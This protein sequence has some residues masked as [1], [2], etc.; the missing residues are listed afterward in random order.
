MRR[1]RGAGRGGGEA[2]FTLVEVLVAFAIASLASLMV[3]RLTGDLTVNGRRIDAAAIRLDEAEGLILVRVAAGTLR[4][5]FEQGRFGDG[6]P[7]TL[8]VVDAG[9]VLGWRDLPPLWRVRLTL[10]GP[11]GRVVYATLV[12]GGLGGG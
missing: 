10:G 1:R 12:A 5:G 9:P 3:L 7:W 4:A 11:E 8:S 2:G 6:Q